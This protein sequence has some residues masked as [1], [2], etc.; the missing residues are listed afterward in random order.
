MNDAFDP[1]DHPIALELPRR[2]TKAAAWVEH[3]P[4]AMTLV[5]LLR[6]R[7]IVELGTYWGD[8]YCAFC[9]AVAKLNLPATGTRCMAVDTWA[10]DAHTG[11]YEGILDNLRAHHDPLYGS[12]SKLRQ[13]TFDQAAGEVADGSVD[14]LHI[15]GL[16]TYDAVR[17]DFDTWLPKISDRGVV[18][19][20]DT[21]ERKEDFGVWK[22]WQE[23]SPRY[24][25]FEFVHGHG[26]GVLGVGS[27]LPQPMQQFF[28]AARA[29]PQRIRDIFWALG[30]RVEHF[31]Q[32]S[33]L[34]SNVFQMVNTIHVHQRVRG[35]PVDASAESAE[36]AQRFPIDYVEYLR[37]LVEQ[38]CGK[39]N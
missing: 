28:A 13:V 26:L 27:S 8:S 24:P 11:S 14:L 3:I 10:G 32:A 37:L 16:H 25:S 6:P 4:F 39:G 5:D 20:H 36:M 7:M 12:F 17:H 29:N 18:L 33:Q 23:V 19:F 31:T 21:A 38:M 1:F 22:L 15:D 35:Q 9:Q 2:M 34:L 30:T